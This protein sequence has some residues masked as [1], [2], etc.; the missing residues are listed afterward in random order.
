MLSLSFIVQLLALSVDPYRLYVE[1]S[2]ATN[3]VIYFNPRHAH[4]VNRPREIVEIW[5]ARHDPGIRFSPGPLPTFAPP[6]LA[7]G[8]RGPQ[9]V[10]K[11]KYLNAYRP[12]WWSFQY[13]PPQQ[14]PVGIV[15]A[16]VTLTAMGLLGCCL[17]VLG[18]RRTGSEVPGTS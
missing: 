9:A 7:R 2:A 18:L 3:P 17:I 1:L 16:A 13:L 8:E 5:R 12:W 4:L 15:S 10:A 14:R 11:Y 6:T